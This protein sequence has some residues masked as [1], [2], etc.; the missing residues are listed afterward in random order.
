MSLFQCEHCG[1]RENTALS[2][3]GIGKFAADWFDWIGI[4]DRKG[5]LLCSACAPSKHSDGTPSGLGEWHDNFP[6]LFLP[7]GEFKTND[8]GNLEHIESG[9]TDLKAF[10]IAK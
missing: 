4:E 3:Q 8:Q 2:C 5:K 7:M 9:S 6:Q 1:G 10:A